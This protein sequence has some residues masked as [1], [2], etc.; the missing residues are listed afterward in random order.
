MIKYPLIILFAFSNAAISKSQILDLETC[1]KMADTANLS[2]RNSR[3][4]IE[5]NER[6]RSAYLSA[7]LPKLTFTGDYKYNAIIPGQV[8]PAAFFGGPPG[9]YS[10]VQFGVPYNL[11]NNLQ[12]AQILYNPQVEYGLNALK[13]NREIVAIQEQLTTLDAKYQVASTFF[14]LQAI[15]K[16]LSFVGANITNME[17]LIRNMEAMALQEMVVQ[18]EVDKLTINKLTLVNAQESLKANKDQLETLLKIL[19]GFDKNAPI[20]IASDELVEKSILVD[21]S[22][23]SYPELDLITAQQKMNDEER[24]GTN[25]SYLPSLSAYASYNYN[26]NLK[27][28]DDFRQGIEG[29][30]IGLRLDWTLFDGLEKFH[31][32]KSNA[33]NADK[34]ANQKEL[35]QQQL[36]LKAENAK[37]QIQVQSGAL[38]I[39]KEQLILAQRVYKH[40][41]LKFEQGTVSSNDLITDENSLQQAQTNVVS[42]YIQLRQAELEYLRS[43]GSIK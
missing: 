16:Q 7:R 42:A 20:T 21:N 36:E 18:T 11:S 4:D 12:L 15:N 13:I 31:K 37:R 38:D 2:I 24:K 40:T 19:I 10:T 34:L 17:K 6:Q 25:M 32:Q 3:L 23:I 8:V 35:A 14:N 43:I 9:T 5:I 28:E 30:F 29:A 26:Y 22:S 1:L 33:L 41:E 39:S 27:P